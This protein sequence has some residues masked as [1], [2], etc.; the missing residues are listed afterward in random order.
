MNLQNGLKKSFLKM[1][2][3]IVMFSNGLDSR[4]VMKI[5]QERGFEIIAVHNKFP[6]SKNVDE[7]VEKFCKEQKIKLKVFDFTKNKLLQDY[8]KII[9]KP[10]FGKG[11]ALNPCIDC[12]ILGLKVAKKFADSKK[13]KIIATGEVLNQRPMSQHAKAMKIV[14]KKSGLN[15]RLLRPLSDY[16]IKGRRRIEQMKLAKKFKITYPGSGGGCLLCEKEYCKK[17]EKVLDKKLSSDD[18]K[19]LS[20]GRHF[21]S[22]EII[23]GRDKKENDILEKHKGWKVLPKQPGAT[24]LVKYKKDI[25]KSKELI[26]KYSK[27]ELEE[28]EIK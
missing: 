22:S 5:M 2:K 9:R 4:L 10:K 18:I 20:V 1:N 11:T 21:E 14:E 7:E 8:L 25:E 27:H 19:L 24:A 15:E 23:L 3:C 13:I 16:G 26:K 17:L 6:F 12:R 28:F